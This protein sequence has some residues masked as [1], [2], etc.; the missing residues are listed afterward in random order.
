LLPPES[1]D[2]GLTDAGEPF[3]LDMQIFDLEAVTPYNLA[4]NMTLLKADDR[5]RKTAA[6]AFL[7]PGRAL[8]QGL[9]AIDRNIAVGQGS[10]A[11]CFYKVAHWNF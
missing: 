8:R 2:F 6:Y 10:Q 1:Q 4:L 9:S 11:L 3:A 7:T 5:W